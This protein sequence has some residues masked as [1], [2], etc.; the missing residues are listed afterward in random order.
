MM[1]FVVLKFPIEFK[2][3]PPWY[4]QSGLSIL[5]S[6]IRNLLSMHVRT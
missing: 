5:G 6:P 1:R 3:E 2:S 4:C